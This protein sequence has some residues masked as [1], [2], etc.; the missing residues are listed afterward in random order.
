MSA[1]PGRVSA[2]KQRRTPDPTPLARQRMLTAA[3]NWR[4]HPYWV[5]LVDRHLPGVA[6]S[7]IG[8]HHDDVTNGRGHPSSQG[9]GGCLSA[10]SAR[11]AI[12]A[13][14]GTR[15][16]IGAWCGNMDAEAGS[17]ERSAEGACIQG[18]ATNMLKEAARKAWAFI[19]LVRNTRPVDQRICVSGESRKSA[20]RSRL[21]S[22][23]WYPGYRPGPPRGSN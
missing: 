17:A 21:K 10:R 12:R 19:R 7:S 2:R 6:I 1:S 4:H 22:L 9:N 14:P 11:P 23:G 20:Q 18:G 15:R 3:A 13:S 5:L 16:Q 8:V